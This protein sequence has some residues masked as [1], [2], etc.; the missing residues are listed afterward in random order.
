M[1]I[2]IHEYEEVTSKINHV[3]KK[4]TEHKV[5]HRDA[6]PGKRLKFDMRTAIGQFAGLLMML[7]CAA[8]WVLIPQRTKD[9]L[10]GCSVKTQ[11]YTQYILQTL[12]EDGV[13]LEDPMVR[14]KLITEM[15]EAAVMTKPKLKKEKP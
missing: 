2:I 4:V 14:R 5:L 12:L 7:S 8:Q 1:N 9:S 10:S 11:D 6:M 13:D 15:N 3:T